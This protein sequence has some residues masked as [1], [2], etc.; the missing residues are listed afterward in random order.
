M[1]PS[2]SIDQ[3]VPTGLEIIIPAIPLDLP[4]TPEQMSVNPHR[5]PREYTPPSQELE[6]EVRVGLAPRIREK[7]KWPCMNTLI[8]PE[9]LGFRKGNNDNINP[10]LLELLSRCLH[11]TEVLLTG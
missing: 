9:A 5:G 1:K 4:A 10:L 2:F 6:A 3:K 8:V 11:L 7:G